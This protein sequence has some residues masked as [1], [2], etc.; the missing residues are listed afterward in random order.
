MRVLMFGWEFPPHITGGL[1]TACFGLTKGLSKHHIDI[2]FVV[3]RAYGDESSEA[4]RLVNASEVS[5]DMEESE[6]QK[7]W[8]RI[9]YMQIGSNIIP[10]VGPEE[11]KE[12]MSKSEL[13][14]ASLESKVLSKKYTFSGKYGQDL[15]EEVSRYALVASAIAAKNEF[16]LIHA[17]DWLT[18]SAG[19]AAKKVSGK[20]LV[21]HMH[22]TEFDRSGEN[23]NQAVFDIEKK[24]MEEADRV[25]T[26]SNL[27]RKIV[28][29]KYGINPDK[30]TTVYNAVEPADKSH[31][32]DIH[33]TVKE[34]VVTFLGR[35]TFQ[36]GPEY[37]I[38]SAKK[39]IDKDSNVRFVMAGTGDMMNRMIKRVAELK[40]ANKFHFTGFLQ[41]QDV[42][43][44]LAVSDVFVMPSVSE[45]FGIVPLE[46]MRSNVPV[47]ISRQSG[48]SEI[49]KHALKVDFWDIDAMADA[50]YGLLHYDALSRMFR[51]YGK[52]EVENL[53][54]ENAAFH[55]KNIYSEL[56]NV[57]A[58]Q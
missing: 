55:V 11:F 16:D 58:K 52:S 35:I 29:E 10:Y 45:P 33:K 53:K 57:T 49:L 54:W 38:E 48:V 30:I 4:A 24:G 14:K 7:Y 56:L 15:L 23:I 3:P 51:K 37:F 32:D 22:A 20:P 19:I 36:K 18:Y 46:A 6:Y 5:V 41:G 39:I 21:V 40:I 27:T 8:K 50:I 43:R 31:L 13:E 44:M 42:D 47:V 34:K 17:H 28:I 26:V 2:L 25:I 9:S 12:I 1:G